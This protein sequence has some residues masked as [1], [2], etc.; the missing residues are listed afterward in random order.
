MPEGTCPGV[1]ELVGKRY[2]VDKQLGEGGMGTV[3]RARHRLTGRRV[4]IK[5]VPDADAT[6]RKRLLREARSMGR[7]SHPNVVAVLDAGEQGDAVYLV[8]ECLEGKNL[9]AFVGRHALEPGEAV[10]LLMPAFAG[11]AAAHQAAILHRDLKPENLFVCTDRDG[12]AYDTKVLDFGVAKVLSAD[13]QDTSLTHRGMI[14]GT[15]KYMAP[16]QIS[17]E[18]R[19]DERTDV[20]ALG[21]ILYEM[22]AGRLPYASTGLRK[23]VSEIEAGNLAPLRSQR[24]DLPEAL[25]DV[26]MRALATDP[27]DRFADVAEFAQALEPFAA[28]RKFEPPRQA[29]TPDGNATLSEIADSEL[30]GRLE[31]KLDATAAHH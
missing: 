3:F 16:E 18:P 22:L 2:E 28:S 25:C 1:G 24:A 8:M 12:S 7:L 21:L 31:S 11:V 14:V 13:T 19:L 20:Y 6:T 15:P 23:M 26:V 9:R 30:W 10:D 29:H 27:N 4:A 5:W 17:P